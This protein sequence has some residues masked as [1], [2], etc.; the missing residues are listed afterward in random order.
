L[1][2]TPQIED[3]WQCLYKEN[4]QDEQD[5]RL[6]IQ[7]IW[8]YGKVSQKYALLLDFKYGMPVEDC[9]IFPGQEREG[10]LRFYPS[11]HPLR[12]VANF[13][14]EAKPMLETP[15]GFPDWDSF[16]CQYANQLTLFPFS[17]EKPLLINS[18][19]PVLAEGKLLLVDSNRLVVPTDLNDS[20]DKTWELIIISGFAPI[21]V[22]GFWQDES[23]KIATF[24]K[25]DSKFY[26]ILNKS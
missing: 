15:S 6:H 16:L 10:K 13:V 20:M 3:V 19:V 11:N 2:N 7:R 5:E 17:S 1:D 9:P 26:E 8:L 25:P 23:F 12:A 4:E 21:T 22:F 24:W 18:V 14:T